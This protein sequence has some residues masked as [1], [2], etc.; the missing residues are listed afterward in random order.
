[1]QP[2]LLG[3]WV[4][5]QPWV[6]LV[7]VLACLP[8]LTNGVELDDVFHAARAGEPDFL[9]S[10]FTFFGDGAPT[11]CVPST[12]LP[13][14]T[15]PGL[16]LDLLRPVAALTHALDY[17]L[18]PHAPWLMHLHSLLWYG[19]L[20]LLLQRT[21]RATGVDA[22]RAALAALV[23][24]LSQAHGMNVGWLAARNSLIGA[25]F[26]TATLLLHHRW[27]AHG[28][29]LD[30]TLAPLLLLL[31]LL[32]NEGAV[33]SMGYLVAYAWVLDDGR[34]RWQALLPYVAVVIAWRVLYEAYGAGAAHSGIY[35]EPTAAPLAY[36]A[37]TVL[38]AFPL[39][40]A[41]LGL[42]VLDPLGSIPG[43]ELAAFV[44]AVPF[45][46]GLGWLA[47]ERVLADRP[48]RAWALGMVLA[49]FTAGTTVPTDRSLLLLSLGGCLVVADLILWLLRQHASRRERVVGWG[50][51][52]VHLVISPLLLPLR[53][54]STAW[55]HGMVERVATAM[56]TGP[57]AAGRTLVLLN[58]PSDL[59]MLYSRAIVQARGDR[60]PERASWLYAAPAALTVTRTA[61]TVIELAAER[62]WLATPL[63]RMFRADLRF[64]VGQRFP[65]ACITAEIVAVDE[66]ALPTAVRFELHDD[67]PGCDLTF[68]AWIDGAPRP[69]TLPEPGTSQ[70]LAPATLP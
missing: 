55:V 68:M 30:A 7:A 13:W 49:C 29:L 47:R 57:D 24:G 8:A 31:A 64:A 26:V 2:R 6:P 5:V 52:V 45:V 10:A 65:S 32:A 42:A 25:T 43:I 53:V 37:R 41:R 44:A 12:D 16:R 63:D 35:L 50:L 14:W 9:R 46:A 3:L 34:R 20:V 48:T 40:A 22:P 51:V 56:P 1:M 18:W 60:F 19:L 54:C 61:P 69:Y 28:S 23:F 59:L 27:R 62:P 39:L 21:L 58:A 36:A 67:R 38:N 33:A 11:P 70:R 17:R 4:R 66:A 15:E